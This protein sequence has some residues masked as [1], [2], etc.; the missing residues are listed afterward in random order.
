MVRKMI[1]LVIAVI[2]VIGIVPQ[3]V[4]AGNDLPRILY[5]E[6]SGRELSKDIY[7]PTKLPNHRT[8]KFIGNDACENKIIEVNTYIDGNWTRTGFLAEFDKTA[9]FNLHEGGLMNMVD[10]YDH[11]YALKYVIFDDPQEQNIVAE[12]P[13]YYVIY[14]D[15]SASEVELVNGVV[16]GLTLTAN[17]LIIETKP[18]YIF[19]GIFG[20]KILLKDKTTGQEQNLEFNNSNPNALG[21]QTN[22]IVYS[23]LSINSDHIYEITIP[24]GTFYHADFNNYSNYK[25][26]IEF[27][28]ELIVEGSKTF[29]D[30]PNDYWAYPYI[31]EL[32]EQ[33][34][35]TGY[36]DGSF[37]PE[38]A[39]TRS[40]FAKM[41]LLSLHIPLSTNQNQSFADVPNSH[42]AFDYIETVK[43]YLTGY[44]NAD[45][46][47]FKGSDLAVR[48]DMA[49]ALVK[50]MGLQNENVNLEE[51][52]TIFSDYAAISP[53][54]QKYVL[55]AYNN[56]LIS[57]YPDGT[58]GAQKTITRAETAALLSKVYKSNAMEKVTFD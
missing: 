27:V 28:S 35:I 54:L 7:N 9:E 14:L 24:K 48:E 58:F 34:V 42:W 4:F 52:K 3:N 13:T 16:R 21:A 53:N 8:L 12:S 51:L 44:K 1:V 40:E 33:R 6:H 57:G 45:E 50:A 5:V 18:D 19:G 17:Q 37:R 41:M 43:P 26:N 49:V 10:L 20:G 23:N 56:Q 39:V 32:T 36:E 38:G 47:Y 30:V 15:E 22:R 25:Y 2:M 11:T 31:K 46:Y 29:E 55:I